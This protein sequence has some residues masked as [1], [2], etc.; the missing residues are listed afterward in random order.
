MGREG[1][2]VSLL[3][4]PEEQSFS[5]PL[6]TLVSAVTLSNAAWICGGCVALLLL[7]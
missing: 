3:S 4:A 6:P 2:G 1:L 7:S 5:M